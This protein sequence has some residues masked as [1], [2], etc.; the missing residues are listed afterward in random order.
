MDD[1]RNLSRKRLRAMVRAGDLIL[2]CYRLLRKSSANVVG[3]VLRGEGEFYEWDHYPKGDAYDP[4]THSQF[5]YHAH[6]VE[7]RGGEHG[8]FHTFLRPKG[9]PPGIRPAPLPDAEAAKGDNDALS[10]L[11]AISMDR[12]G[13]PNRLFTTNRWVTGETWYV[14]QDVIGMLDRFLVDQAL[15]SL[16]VN[17]WIT[18]MV[19]LFRPLIED[20]LGRRDRAVSD[21]QAKFPDRNVYEDRDLEIASVATISIEDQIG[22]V[23]EALKSAR[24]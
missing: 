11:I 23:Q 2:D 14:A 10:H 3:E 21:H 8:H 1:F 20:L 13:Y 12:A 17:I 18:N 7:L 19:C 24:T 16:P 22:R 9:M 6:P 15:P 4:E 5:Y